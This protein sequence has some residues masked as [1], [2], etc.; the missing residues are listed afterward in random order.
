[1][2]LLCLSL[3]VSIAFYIKHAKLTWSDKKLRRARTHAIFAE[4]VVELV[5]RCNLRSGVIFC[6][7]QGPAMG[8]QKRK[9]LPDLLVKYHYWCRWTWRIPEKGYCDSRATIRQRLL[10]SPDRAQTRTP[11]ATLFQIHRPVRRKK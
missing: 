6:D 9:P 11:V 1:M 8:G 4:S 3:Q 10:S 2:F 5:V 7:W